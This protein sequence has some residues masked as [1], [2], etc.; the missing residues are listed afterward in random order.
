MRASKSMVKTPPPLSKID[1]ART[2]QDM[3]NKQDKRR[4]K[5]PSKRYKWRTKDEKQEQQ[6][7]GEYKQG[8]ER[9]QAPRAP[10]ATEGKTHAK[11]KA[12]EGSEAAS[13]PHQAQKQELKTKE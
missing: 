5:M 9:H 10:M 11:Q 4:D 6:A 13:G 7:V 3:R 12:S 8:T 1:E 2:K